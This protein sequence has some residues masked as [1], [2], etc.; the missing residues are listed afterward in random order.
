M[1]Q[2]SPPRGALIELVR[3]LGPSAGALV[4]VL[5]LL[6]PI[7]RDMLDNQIDTVEQLGEMNGHLEHMPA[8]VGQA[9]ARELRYY[10]YTFEDDSPADAGDTP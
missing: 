4:V 8:E 9:V 2:I 6:V 3:I 5:V 10:E 7:V 1:K